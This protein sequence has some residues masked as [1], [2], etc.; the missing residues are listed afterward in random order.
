[1]SLPNDLRYGFR[2]MNRSSGFTAVA[3]LCLAL[4]IGGCVAVFALFEE[5]FLSP[6]PGV[7]DP[8]GLVDLIGKPI[9][10][11]EEEQTFSRGLSYPDFLRFQAENQV[12][13]ELAAFQP[14]PVQGAILGRREAFR[15]RGQAVTDNFF[16][17]L[18]VP[19]AEG[20]LFTPGGGERAAAEGEVVIAYGLA[21]RHFGSVRQALDRG[22]RV[23]GSLYTVVGVAAPG[24]RGPHRGDEADFWFPIESV[25]MLLPFLGQE[26]LSDPL[27]PW[28]FFFTGR[29][30][31]GVDLEKAQELLDDLA[32]RIG[33]G[34]PP[35]ERTPELQLYPGTGLPPGLRPIVADPISVLAAVVGLLMLVV[36]ANLGGLLLV[37][38]AARQE[39]IG[40]RVALGVTRGRLVRQLLTESL[41]LSLLG[42]GLG[43]VV[44]LYALDAVEGFSL[45]LHL[46]ELRGLSIDGRVLTFA[47]GLSI[48]TGLLCGLVPAV[49]SWRPR[50]L[51]L[52]RRSPDG[53]LDSRRT[54]IQ[55]ALVVGQV[56]L[57]LV[58]LIL[59]GLFLRTLLN[60]RAIDPGFEGRGVVNLR[61]DLEL[62]GY[63]EPGERAFFQKVLEQARQ[64]P[65][66]R[67]A[68]LASNVPLS[69]HN[70][71]GRFVRAVPSG[72]DGSPVSVRANS[73]SPGYFDTLNIRLLEGRDFTQDDRP[74]AVPA[75]ILTERLAKSFWPGRSPVGESLQVEGRPHRV[76]GLVRDLRTVSLADEP[77]PL[78]YLPLAQH[79]APT[80]ALHLRSAGDPLA[81]VTPIRRLVSRLD[82]AVPVYDVHLYEEEVDEA[83]AQPRAFAWLFGAFSLIA[84]VITAIGLYGTLA[85]AVSCRTRE[86][87]IRMALGA[88]ATEIVGLVLRRGLALTGTGLLLGLLLASFANT[89]FTGLLVGVD[90]T[91]P[92]VFAAVALL[93]SLVGFAASWLPAYS[94]TRV[95][96]M[97]VIRHE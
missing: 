60:L 46:P 52:M 70:W 20:R 36:C 82:P 39:E 19:A 34:R 37:R 40:V 5:M 97:R 49:W 90:P 14:V 83:L 77:I 67:A 85:Y 47:M 33:A 95:D 68:A 58:L 24:F 75:V 8:G 69:T 53:G 42:G 57:S 43:V 25:P 31:P 51:P 11:G 73:V 26:A 3:L 76:V 2:K 92:G 71:L 10:L 64:L 65:E 74:G 48:L 79:F 9:A 72:G 35:E 55:E 32:A 38:A 66:V 7:S 89:L 62:Q 12:F 63:P 91:D 6:V 87:G 18:G 15:L 4:G 44:A 78:L 93:L 21:R 80:L 16:T 94:A 81:L 27:R 45:G 41:A 61:L 29:L 84:V 86:L 17:T 28:M 30:A 22:L 13:S 1:M 54:R 23:N 59:A 50:L 88:R 56:T 96:P